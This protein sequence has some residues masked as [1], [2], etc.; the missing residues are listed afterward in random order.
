MGKEF[1]N[2]NVQN[3]LKKHQ[4]LFDVFR[5]EDIGRRTVQPYIEERHMKIVYAQQKL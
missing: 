4:P 2:A 5:N 1:Y 3:L